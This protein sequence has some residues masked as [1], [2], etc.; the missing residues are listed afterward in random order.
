VLLKSKYHELKILSKK[1]T[2]SI[3]LDINI[4]SDNNL[5][6]GFST[7]KIRRRGNKKREVKK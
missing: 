7:L 2:K 5:M 1:L 4:I 6:M 3:Y